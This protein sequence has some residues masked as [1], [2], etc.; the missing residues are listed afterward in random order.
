MFNELKETQIGGQISRALKHLNDRTQAENFSSSLKCRPLESAA[1]AGGAHASFAPASR[2]H[3]L[4]H[5]LLRVTGC[6][7]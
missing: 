3:S 2:R 5:S 4:T 7:S 6:G 1:R